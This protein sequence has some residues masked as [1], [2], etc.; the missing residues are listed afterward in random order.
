MQ[1]GQQQQQQ[2]LQQWQQQSA[3]NAQQFSRQM[4]AQHDQFMHDQAVRQTM[5]EQF[6]ATMQR[7][8]DA[9]TARTQQSMNARSTAASDWV[10]YALDQKTVADP[11]TGQISKVSNSYTHTWVDSTGKTTYQTNDSNA[12][13]NGVLPGNWTQQQTVHGDGTPQ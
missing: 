3:Q 5:H 10:G 7:G 6:L 4:Q 1:R 8:T 11:N 13:P 12:N 2:Q 9:S